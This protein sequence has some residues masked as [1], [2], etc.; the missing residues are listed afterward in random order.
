MPS[1][2]ARH[3]V[4]ADAV[5]AG[6]IG[7]NPA[8]RRRGRG[9]RAGRSAERGPE[10]II[11]DPL[12]ALLIAERAA[13][14]AGR[15]DEFVLVTLAH[16]TGI[17]WAEVTGLETR[18]A[19]LRSIRVEWQLVELDPGGFTRCPPKEGSYRD[20]GIPG[21]MAVLGSDHITR[22]A[23]TPCACHG[24]IYIFRGQ[25]GS[26]HWRRSGFGDWVFEPAVYG[27]FPKRAPQP[28]RPV[29]IFPEPW[30]GRP[31]RGRDNQARAEAWWVPG[32]AGT[33][34]HALAH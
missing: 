21:W 33:P 10:R 31:V 24:F 8:T 17:R 1:G 30:P 34:L 32:S 29:P 9:K 14:L 18:Y 23:P 19:R 28:R 4:L 27:W 22:A 11:T 12:G 20:V 5:D 25:R 15:D 26:A 3:T 7:A 16:Y 2:L 6:L 13:I